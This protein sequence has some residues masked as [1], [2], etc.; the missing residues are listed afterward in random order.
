[1]Y[2]KPILSIVN[3]T[4]IQAKHLDVDAMYQTKL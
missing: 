2:K 4:E 3:D 1:M